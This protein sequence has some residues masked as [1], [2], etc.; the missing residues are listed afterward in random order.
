MSFAAETKKELT[1]L[2]SDAAASRFELMAILALGAVFKTFDGRSELAIETENVATA[3]RI[4]T[5]LKDLC[6]VRPEVVVRK[7][8]RLKKNHVYTVRLPRVQAEAVLSDLGYR[9]SYE[10]G[11]LSAAWDLP[12][13]DELRRAFLRGAFLAGGSVNAPGSSSYHL[14]I[15][16][17][18]RDL[19]HWVHELMNVY[20]L[21]ARMT[22]RKKGYIVYIKEVEKIVDFLNIIGAV[23][24][25]L[26]FEDRRILKGMRN[27]VNRLVNCETANMNKTISAAV[28]QLEHIR[29]IEQTIGLDSL[30]EHLREVADI[31]L[32]HPEA[33]LQELSKLLN[34]RV[35]KSGLNH[36]FRKLEEIALQHRDRS[37]IGQRTVNDSSDLV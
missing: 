34:G 16:A 12:P 21:H 33:N 4:Y 11:P 20:E 2:T 6:H 9:G 25:L 17:P 1:Q 31:R 29:W 30:P 18:S 13:V 24:A 10:E 23:R 27:Q 15:Y 7:K 8:M 19:A 14:E 37:N 36:R 35:T 26:Q 3:R 32:R 22:N 28:R 5:S